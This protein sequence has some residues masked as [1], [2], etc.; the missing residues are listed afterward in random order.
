MSDTAGPQARPVF[1]VDEFI[2][3]TPRGPTR[4]D[5]A[6]ADGS[7]SASVEP[8]G[9]ARRTGALIDARWSVRDPPQRDNAANA[10]VDLYG[11]VARRAAK[12]AR[13][14]PIRYRW[15]A[16]QCGLRPNQSA[17][18]AADSAM[19]RLTLKLTVICV[20]PS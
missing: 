10:Q 18:R 2:I 17:K 12:A 3:S 4:V 5:W 6:D 9:A 7:R 13:T 16:S 14:V 8:L 19:Q 15:V 20:R 11:S 1:A